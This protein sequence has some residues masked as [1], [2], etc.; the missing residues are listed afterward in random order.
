MTVSGSGFAPTAGLS[1]AMSGHVAAATFVSAAEVRCALPADLPIGVVAVAVA[2]AEGSRSEGAKPLEPP[3]C[4]HPDLAATFLIWQPPSSYGRCDV[5]H[6]RRIVA[7]DSFV[8]LPRH[9]HCRCTP[10]HHRHRLEPRR[11]SR[12]EPRGISR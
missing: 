3:I 4:H 7:P 2:V 5:P 11:N 12:R 9:R 8:N 10:H 1:C 6:V